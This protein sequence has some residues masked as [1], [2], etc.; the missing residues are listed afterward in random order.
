MQIAPIL[1]LCTPQTAVNAYLMDGKLPDNIDDYTT[2]WLDQNCLRKT[3]VSETLLANNARRIQDPASRTVS[4]DQYLMGPLLGQV[5]GRLF[6][7]AK[8]YDSNNVLLDTSI[9]ITR[10]A[11][12]ASQSGI[13]IS[14]NLSYVEY[15]FGAPVRIDS[16]NIAMGGHQ[17]FVTNDYAG[18]GV[19]IYGYTASGTN[20][21]LNRVG[22]YIQ[23][24]VPVSAQIL[25][26]PI[27]GYSKIRVYP[28]YSGYIPALSFFGS[29][30]GDPARQISNDRHIVVYKNLGY[31]GFDVTQDL[32]TSSGADVYMPDTTLSISS[33]YRLPNIFYAQK[34]ITG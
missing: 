29:Y 9:M 5:S 15:D 24:Y 31:I 10:R 8:M 26:G 17:A 6:P 30:T 13:P 7:I 2:S 14:G 21:L 28:K 34:T 27:S 23:T 4:V 3:F 33:A 32:L 16:A 22:W 12:P 19:S 20:A 18:N 11:S 1:T 25:S